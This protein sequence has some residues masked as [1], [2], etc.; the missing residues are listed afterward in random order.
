MSNRKWTPGPWVAVRNSSYWEIS[1]DGDRGGYNGLPHRVG[2]V[3]ESCPG[4]PDGGLQEGN[5]RLIAAAPELY[6]LLQ[7]ALATCCHED[8]HWLDAARAAL[9]KARGE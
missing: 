6:E 3:C 1:P 9:K 8:W 4:D 7:D 2:S 5:A